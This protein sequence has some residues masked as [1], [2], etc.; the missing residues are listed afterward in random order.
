VTFFDTLIRRQQAIKFQYKI[1]TFDE[2]GMIHDTKTD[3]TYE[4]YIALLDRRQT[5]PTKGPGA[6]CY[7]VLLY[8]VVDGIIC[9]GYEGEVVFYDIS[10]LIY[11]TMKQYSK[12]YPAN[13]E[14]YKSKK[15]GFRIVR[16]ND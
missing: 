2:T 7:S 11:N 5:D 14:Y 3:S 16:M 12:G 15:S 1:R 13:T 4:M 10:S 6:F 8:Y 9:P